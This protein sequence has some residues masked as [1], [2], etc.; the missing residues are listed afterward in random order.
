MRENSHPALGLWVV[1]SVALVGAF[2]GPAVGPEAEAS[3]ATG[4][5]VTVQ[6]TPALAGIQKIQHVVVIMQENRSFDEYFGMYPGVD[7]IP[8][9]AN[10]TPT[11]CVPDPKTQTCVYPYHDPSDINLGGPHNGQ[12]NQADI[13]GGKMDGF[14]ANAE[15]QGATPAQADTVMGYKLRSDLPNYWAYADNFV[16][17]DH[18][19]EPVGSWSGPSHLSL[20]SG[21]SATCPTGQVTSCVSSVGTDQDGDL[22]VP[23]GPATSLLGDGDDDSPQLSASD[24]LWTDLSYLLYQHGVTW[25]YYR[26]ASTP[27]IWNPLPDF[28]DVHSDNQLGNVSLVNNLYADAAAG[29]LPAVSWVV[30]SPDVS[31]HPAASVSASQTY[32]TGVINSLMQ[33]P[34]WSSTA[35]FLAW[36]DWGG[37]YDHVVPPSVDANGYGMRVPGLLISPY[38]RTGS[39]DH[40]TLSF[41]AYLKFI[42]DD[43]L[44][45]QRLDPATDGRPDPRPDVR[46]NAAVLGDLTS[47][48]DFTQ[49]PRPPLL[50]Q[51]SPAGG[52][53]RRLAVAAAS[54]ADS[55][56]GTAPCAVNLSISIAGATSPTSTWSLDFG[57]GTPPATGTGEPTAPV[58]HTYARP[59]SY[60]ATASVTDGNGITTTGT[61]TVQVG[62]AIPAPSLVA[63]R[64]LGLAPLAVTFDGSLS[65]DADDPLAS[66]SLTFGDGSP[67]ATGVGVPPADIAHTYSSVG[68]FTATLT[69]TDEDGN[70][71][72]G[73]SQIIQTGLAKLPIASTYPASTTLYGTPVAAGQE[74]LLGVVNPN[75]DRASYYFQ[76]GPTSAYGSATPTSSTN[77]TNIADPVSALATSLKTH[78]TYHY[79]LVA[80]N[81]TGTATGQDR[82]FFSGAGIP[83]VASG[84]LTGNTTASVT[85]HATVNPGGLATS[86]HFDYG[87]S[88]SYGLTT[89]TQSVGSGLSPITITAVLAN[90]APKTLYHYRISATNTAGTSVS[91]DTT[92]GLFPPLVTT[93]GAGS[94]TQTAATIGGAVNPNLLVTRFHVDYGLTTSYSSHTPAQTIG[95]GS[96]AI[97]VSASLSRLRPGTI[98]HYRITATNALGTVSGGDR[99]LRTSGTALATTT[100]VAGVDQADVTALGTVNPGGSPTTYWFEYGPSEAYGQTTGADTAGTG[101]A[102]VP[103]RATMHGIKPGTLYHYRLVADSNAGVAYGADSAFLRGAPSVMTAQAFAVAARSAAVGGLVSPRADAT[104]YVVQYGMTP[105]YG[106]ASSL[107]QAGG[108]DAKVAVFAHLTGLRPHTIYHYRLLATNGFGTS[109]GVDRTFTTASGLPPLVVDRG[110]TPYGLQ[111]LL[112]P[113]AFLMFARTRRRRKLVR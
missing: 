50:L 26:A 64:A 14:I 58:A 38:A 46:E 48:F 29:T 80:T 59:G 101:T 42:E 47:E 78:T 37:L 105:S 53:A 103:V 65:T 67:P 35:I 107:K 87:R 54:P 6:A 86:A 12:D 84:L 31:D 112:P 62:P 73:A 60:T 7:G 94:V 1:T 43:F 13:D 22:A 20:V 68:T 32:V 70:A 11:T 40:Q 104:T 30:P 63:Y 33:S 57:D 61:T 44:G 66:W 92:F 71:S 85:A 56:V 27:E 10:G 49:P 108:G 95:A 39:I 83:A 23:N 19:Y 93:G 113:P 102:P 36:D 41:D 45:G 5:T 16:L 52:Q 18:M 97:A 81:G 96:I 55:A 51:P 28:Q 109:T 69:V 24:Y 2:V 82:T 91:N 90:L 17:Q 99:M 88:S 9:D 106:S 34:E 77:F 100:G 75:F 79:R 111:W 21:W 72:P 89:P 4:P 25:R 98:Y 76:Y 3:P 110:G 74:L 8:L 15:S